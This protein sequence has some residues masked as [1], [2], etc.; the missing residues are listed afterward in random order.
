MSY[1]Q[2]VPAR[3]PATVTLATTVLLLMAVLALAYVVVGLLVVG[4]TVD[5][6][7][8][9]ASGSSATTDDIDGV[10]ALLRTSAV[11][12]AVINVLAAVL[13][14]VLALGVAGGRPGA[15]VATWVVCGLGLLCGCC[16][17]TVLV[18]QRSTPLR[19][20]ADDQA[21]AELL[22]LVGDAYPPWWIPLSAGLSVGQ[23]LGYLVVAVLLALP[24]A[25][26]WFRRRPPAPSVPPGFP[27]SVPPGFP[28]APPGFP[29]APH[30]PP[31]PYPPR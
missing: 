2:P 9:A 4:G 28:P 18:V 8:S 10:V 24:A 27:P 12:A 31:P 23:A 19:L 22:N 6:F 20:G 14:A 1:P 11:L 3:R 29:P 17:L 30:Q 25:N 21:T 16:G 5:R 26:V 7:R 15:R 13:L